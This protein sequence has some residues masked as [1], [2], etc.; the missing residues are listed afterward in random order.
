[1]NIF[2]LNPDS[3][4]GITGTFSDEESHHILN[5]LRT[6]TGSEICAV[7]GM[8][9]RY[10]G[11]LNKISK[12]S[13]SITIQRTEREEGIVPE[14]NIYVGLLKNR[15][16]MEWMVEKLTETGVNQITF[17]QTER[18]ERAKLRLDRFEAIAITAMKQSLRAT[19]PELNSKKLSEIEIA[20]GTSFVAHEVKDIELSNVDI[21]NT[22]HSPI[23]IFIGPEGGFT[24]KEVD[25][26]KEKIHAH[27]L[28]LGNLRLR[29]ETAA[30][31][32]AGLFRYK[33]V[34]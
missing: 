1:M 34:Y 31:H 5:V 20:S 3:V 32:A 27:R 22:K 6:P 12:K 24:D 7:D 18:T 21:S 16:R 14:I 4:S 13:A 30:I 8:G 9:S 15:Q 29:T 17:L 11:I 28:W 23:H 33:E 26:L 10:F 19:L 2:Y 25:Y